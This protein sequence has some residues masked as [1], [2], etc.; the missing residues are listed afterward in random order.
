M[1]NKDYYKILGINK[2]STKEELKKAYKKLAL[3]YHPDKAPKEKEKEY[4][5]KFKEI[6]E[7]YS[8]LSDNS[9]RKNYDTFGNNDFN[10]SSGGSGFGGQ[11]FG[12]FRSDDL[13]SIFRDLFGGSDFGNF[14]R[15][16]GFGDS[17][18][19][20]ESVK[21]GRD[22][23]YELSISLEE[24]VFGCEKE[25]EIV[26][27]VLCD[28][29]E[30]TGAEN[31][32]FEKCDKC[33]GTGKLSINRRTPF[34]IFRQESLCDKCEG[35]GK[36]PKQKCKTCNGKGII[37]K[38]IKIKIKIPA[39]IDTGQML[40]VLGKGEVVKN[41]KPGNLF[42]VINV[43]PN[44][45]FTRRGDDLFSNLLIT[46]S[47][48]A[49]GCK[50][51]VPTMYKDETIKI[52]AGIESETVLRLKGKGISNLKGYSKGDQFIT[53]KIKTPKKLNRQQK[54]IFKELSK[55]DKKYKV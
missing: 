1:T 32:K 36:I 15:S 47:Q 43:K 26:K 11:G 17:F 4:E 50:I 6:S 51:K 9:K 48:A 35:T 44:K 33:E 42:V 52:P 34:G 30:G 18:Y 21:R 46:F 54:N 13:S 31:K 41:G 40:K 2:S 22:L 10:Q 39:G 24:S 12:N 49:L 19:D 23:Q 25:I 37:N 8:I 5:E 45:T 27:P 55:I 7:A 16:S 38:K 28:K 14:G 53:I 3:K 20:G 29:C